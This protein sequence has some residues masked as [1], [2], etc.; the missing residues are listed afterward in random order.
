M[1][2]VTQARDNILSFFKT[3]WD[4]LTPPFPVVYQDEP[5][6]KPGTLTP[7]CRVKLEHVTGRQ[8]TLCGSTGD[9]R[10]TREGILWIQI[11]SPMGLGQFNSDALAD[12]LLLSL[13]RGRFDGGFFKD[14]RLNEVGPS[15]DWWQVNLVCPFEYDDIH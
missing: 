1:P 4:N 2:T 6:Q 3:T 15:G 5:T 8:R 7:W 10:F 11:F 14:V 13:E 9:M 12:G